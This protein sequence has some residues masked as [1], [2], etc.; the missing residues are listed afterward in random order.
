M[1]VSRFARAAWIALALLPA[2]TLRAD[3]L[4]ETQFVN[5]G[6]PAAQAPFLKGLLLLHSFEFGDAADAFREAQ[7]ADP[8][9]ALAYWGEAMSA[10]HPIWGEQDAAAARG[11]LTRLAPTPEARLSKA[12]TE[13]ERDYLRAIDALYGPGGKPE[14]DAAYSAAMARMAARYP[15]DL[16][17]RA[18]YALS[19]LGLTG[20]ERDEKNYMRAA[21]V[22]E[23][24]YEENPRHPGALHY[25]IHA[26]D[27]PIH[28]PLGLRAARRY[29]SLA[30]AASHAQHMP[31]HIFFALGMWADAV[32]ANVASMKT[33]RDKGQGGYHPL[34]WLEYAYLQQGQPELAAP[35][36][37]LVADDVKRHPTPMARIHLAMTRATWL[38][39]TGRNDDVGD[40]VDRSGIASIGGFA[41]LAFARGLVAANAT[42]LPGAS[43]ALGELKEMIETGRGALRGD[44]TAH[45]HDH[46]S[47]SE[48]KTAE[49]MA[50]ELEAAVLF[51]SGKPAEALAEARRAAALEDEGSFQY[52]P[53]PTVKPPHEL[54]GDLLLKAKRRAEARAEFTKAL[55]RAPNRRLSVIGLAACGDGA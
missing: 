18:F 14:R 16:D 29:G 48:L 47:A 4:G 37:A 7:K 35:L 2:A 50:R 6:S 20:T 55:E 43:A 1:L 11:A 10:N 40:P 38:V 19:L 5:S 17:A 8:G 44:D 9:F 30:P 26:Y 22:A 42:D 36:V 52:G 32:G 27:D 46:V 23:E 31:S 12:P 41:D 13:R 51:A 53:P 28:A 34:H 45:G 24:V 15:R 39:E 33:A 21:A 25:L 54:L 49:V 3:G